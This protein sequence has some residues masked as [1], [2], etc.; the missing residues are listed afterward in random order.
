MFLFW[1]LWR[2][3]SNAAKRGW[4]LCAGVFVYGVFQQA[5]AMIW[6]PALERV[7]PMQPMRYLH[8]IYFFMALIGG[9]LLGKFAE[10]RLAVGGFSWWQM[11][12]C[13]CGNDWSL[14]A[15]STWSCR[16]GPQ[17]I[18]GCRLS[19]DATNTPEEPTSPWIRTT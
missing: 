10:S 6:S 18:P 12:A 19:L 4:Q 5:V 8:L 3:A 9:G 17:R 13:F 1:L 7:T 14:Q 2:V 15:A 11:A 16:G